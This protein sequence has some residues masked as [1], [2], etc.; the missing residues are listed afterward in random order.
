MI[1]D[2]F[3]IYVLPCCF[4]LISLWLV[5]LLQCPQKG[6]D[7]DGLV[8]PQSEIQHVRFR[9]PTAKQQP[10]KLS[11]SVVSSLR[12]AKSTALD[13]SDS[14]QPSPL[15]SERR[16]DVQRSVR[17]KETPVHIID[18][19]GSGGNITAALVARGSSALGA[20]SSAS[21]G[22][23][24]TGKRAKLTLNTESGLERPMQEEQRTS[25]SPAVSAELEVLGGGGAGGRGRLFRRASVDL[26]AMGMRVGVEP[27]SPDALPP[28]DLTVVRRACASCRGQEQ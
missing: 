7:A 14:G 28:E 9:E 16:L 6:K 27:M 15:M 26:F 1:S 18:S 19:N 21:G 22:G 3:K 12:G 2:V 25:N 10:S 24:D 4:A 13:S 5:P 11:Q 20:G 23:I 17:F 8:R